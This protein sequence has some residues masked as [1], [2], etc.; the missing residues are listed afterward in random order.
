MKD[1]IGNEFHQV[2]KYTRDRLP[3]HR[4]DPRT[5]PL[6]FKEYPQAKH[7]S[8]PLSKTK[9]G[10]GL[11]TLLQQ[12]RSIRTFTKTSISLDHLSQLLWATQGVTAKILTPMGGEYHLR[13]APSAGGLYPIE[14]YLCINNVQDLAPGIYHYAVPTHELD[15]LKPG[16]FGPQ[17]A[18][19]ALEQEFLAQSNV[20]FIWTA[21]FQ[22]SKW[23][24][25]QRAFRYVF[26][27]AGHIAQN[28]A[29]AAEALSLGSCQVGAFYDDEL[30][31]I[32]DINGVQES[33]LYLSGVGYK[34][35]E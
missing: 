22:R 26:L 19:A 1:S 7:V 15:L 31:S 23:K 21:V 35:N 27:D 11:W 20:V 33:V 5:K 9:D 10:K 3:R 4:L 8:L 24:Y 16:E 13:T 12:R 17:V 28:L 25:L 32:I 2:T 6:A 30:N 18:H 29:L 14:T 34:T